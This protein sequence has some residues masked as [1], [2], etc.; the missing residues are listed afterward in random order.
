MEIRVGLDEV[1]AHFAELEDPRSEINRL[2]PLESVV[3]IAIMA[4]LA[5]ASG[6]TSTIGFTTDIYAIGGLAFYLI[7]RQ[8]PHDSSLLL[9]TVADEDLSS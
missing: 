9:D 3:V 7:T 6:P 1:I 8:S 5:G 2:H 4:I